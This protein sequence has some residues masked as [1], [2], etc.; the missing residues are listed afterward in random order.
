MND[1]RFLVQALV[2]GALLA[3]LGVGVFLLMYFVVLAGAD[4]LARLLGSLLVPPLL[5]ALVIGGYALVRQGD[6]ES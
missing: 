4:V 2:A 1:N 6:S 5:I 3:V